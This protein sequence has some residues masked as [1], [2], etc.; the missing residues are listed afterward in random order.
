MH[1]YHARTDAGTPDRFIVTCPVCLWF[2]RAQ[3]KYR[4]KS[5]IGDPR[6]GAPDN[7]PPSCYRM[8][9]ENPLFRVLCRQGVIIYGDDDV[10]IVPVV[11]V[12]RSEERSCRERV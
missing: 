9:L 3:R 10:I 4:S 7:K 8:S 12:V 1:K 5:E 6:E 2:T 11:I